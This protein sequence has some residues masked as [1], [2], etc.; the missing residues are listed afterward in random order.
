MWRPIEWIARSASNMLARSDTRGVGMSMSIK[1]LLAGAC[2]L[3]TVT[4][5]A[6]APDRHYVVAERSGSRAPLPFSEGVVVGDTLYIAG[7]I[8]LDPKTDKAADNP[9][10]EARLVMAA[11]QHTVAAAG[12][13]MDGTSPGPCTDICKS[14]R[15]GRKSLPRSVD[16]HRCGPGSASWRHGLAIPSATDTMG[17]RYSYPAERSELEME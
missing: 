6:S 4:V 10:Q 11:V 16:H 3:T 7:H 8:G 15:R 2:L 9:E 12:F 1:S 17:R 13:Q 14:C 5:A